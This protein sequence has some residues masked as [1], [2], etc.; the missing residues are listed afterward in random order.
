M[1]TP[2][3]ARLFIEHIYQLYG[4]LANI[5]SDKDQKNYSH[6]WCTVLKRLDMMLNMSM[7]DHQQSDGQ[8]K[9]NNQVLDDIQSPM[10]IN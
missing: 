1:E 4:F 6:F 8:T 5:L 9:C 10:Y 7:A 3:L 2:E